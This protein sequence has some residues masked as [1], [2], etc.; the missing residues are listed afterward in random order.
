MIEYTQS[1]FSALST[2]GR[3]TTAT[4]VSVGLL[5]CLCVLQATSAEVFR[6][7]KDGVFRC[8]AFAV[9]VGDGGDIAVVSGDVS[10][11]KWNVLLDLKGGKLSSSAAKDLIDGKRVVDMKNG[12]VEITGKLK[13][14]EG[15]M[16]NFSERLRIVAGGVR[17][18]VAVTTPGGKTKMDA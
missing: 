11:A 8:G 14:V 10:L 18:K 16:F 1:R 13:A 12:L 17:V 15:E 7:D 2:S 6:L 3:R 9:S 5:L 4:K